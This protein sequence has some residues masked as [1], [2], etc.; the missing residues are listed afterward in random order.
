MES[1]F[2]FE[3]YNY[4]CFGERESWSNKVD[5][6]GVANVEVVLSN[7]EEKHEQ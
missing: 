3:K 5:S 2:I 7:N 6:E 1:F 4:T